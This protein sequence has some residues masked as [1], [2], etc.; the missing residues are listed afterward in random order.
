MDRNNKKGRSPCRQLTVSESGDY[1][2][3]VPMLRLQ[4]QC[5]EKAG[6]PAGTKVVVKVREGRIVLLGSRGG[7]R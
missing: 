4:G 7:E 6:F 2:K 5:L 1:H 3:S